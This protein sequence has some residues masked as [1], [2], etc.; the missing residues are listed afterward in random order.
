[1]HAYINIYI[2]IS[3]IFLC[4]R[5]SPLLAATD[6]PSPWYKALPSRHCTPH[7]TS[8]GNVWSRQL[9]CR[10]LQYATHLKISCQISYQKKSR[11]ESIFFISLHLFLSLKFTGIVLSLSDKAIVTYIPMY[12][13][14]Y[15]RMWFSKYVRMYVHVHLMT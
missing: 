10:S 8:H 1:M 6:S 15:V 3:C 7:C 13:Y 11:D 12:V 5:S 14:T 4:C 2:Y 9:V